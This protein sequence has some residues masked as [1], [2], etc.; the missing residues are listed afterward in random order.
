V[1]MWKSNFPLKYKG[2]CYSFLLSY[3]QEINS[4]FPLHTGFSPLHPHPWISFFVNI[5]LGCG[6]LRK[7]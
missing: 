5:F 7:C 1:N 3:P 4:P 2:S 6:I